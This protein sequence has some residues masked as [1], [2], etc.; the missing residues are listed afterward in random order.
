MDR[1]ADPVV[2][3]VGVGV[4]RQDPMISRDTLEEGDLIGFLRVS[5]RERA[6]DRRVR[7][8][9]ARRLVEDPETILQR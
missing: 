8:L 7:A 1:R 4:P 2:H 3:N 9:A 5:I 6:A